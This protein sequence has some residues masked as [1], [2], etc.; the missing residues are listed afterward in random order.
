ML[1]SEPEEEYRG[2]YARESGQ[3]PR[4]RN[5]LLDQKNGFDRENAAKLGKI[6]FSVRNQV[7]T[8]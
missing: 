4:T 3:C 6:P 7:A 2:T 1:A 8:F 5:L